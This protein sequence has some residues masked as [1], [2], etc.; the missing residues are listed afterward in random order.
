MSVINAIQ[1]VWS[2]HFG[3][4]RILNHDP[5]IITDEHISSAEQRATFYAEQVHKRGALNEIRRDARTSQTKIHALIQTDRVHQV[6]TRQAQRVISAAA[7]GQISK[8]KA[9]A[10][11]Q[12]KEKRQQALAE[13]YK[14]FLLGGN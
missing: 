10:G 12:S 3:E 5:R 8:A 14:Q 7:D 13:D 1:D 6:V 4:D 2:A 11:T 9:L